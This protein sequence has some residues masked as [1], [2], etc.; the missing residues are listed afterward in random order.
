MG[1]IWFAAFVIL[2]LATGR[3][4]RVAPATPP[5]SAAPQVRAA[6]PAPP[7][8]KPELRQAAKAVPQVSPA[9]VPVTPRRA[10]PPEAVVRPGP[11][12]GLFEDGRS[13]V[14]AVVAA[15]VFGPPVALRKAEDRL[16]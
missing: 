13:L 14:R 5:V 1:W 12:D 6:T 8:P 16:H 11:L 2:M 7:R 10:A 3:R 15:E 9:Q 4:K